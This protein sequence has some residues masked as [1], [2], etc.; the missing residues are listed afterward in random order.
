MQRAIFWVGLG[1]IAGAAAI[2][3][4]WRTK[5]VTVPPISSRKPNIL[6]ISSC[7]LRYAHLATYSR[8]TDYS[9]TITE[10][11]R[12][13]FVF[14]NAVTE[15][16]WTN[17][18]NFLAEDGVRF[19]MKYGYQM[20]GNRAHDPDNPRTR[21]TSR[22]PY[23][24]RITDSRDSRRLRGGERL[25]IKDY[26]NE[27]E[28]AYRTTPKPFL[29]QVHI[30]AMHLPYLAMSQ[31]LRRLV[32]RKYPPVQ[33]Y[34]TTPEK[35]PE[36][37]ALFATLL[38]SSQMADYLHVHPKRNR[39]STDAVLKKDRSKFIGLAQNPEFLQDW[40]TSSDFVEDVRLLKM[41]YGERLQWY[42]QEIA[43]L[44][45]LF[46]D[47]ELR[48]NTVIIFTGDHGEAM[49]EHGL[50][51]HGEAPWEE[52]IRIPLMVYFPG[53][54]TQIRL[55]G[56]I[57]SASTKELIEGLMSGELRED[58]FVEWVQKNIHDD[59]AFGRDCPN[60][61]QSVRYRNQW[62]LF[63]SLGREKWQLFDLKNDPGEVHDV[64]QRYPG[65]AA[66]LREKLESYESTPTVGHP[67]CNLR[68][69][70]SQRLRKDTEDDQDE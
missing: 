11:G 51:A 7:S 36:K 4:H 45:S 15:L 23:F 48:R 60:L 6:V 42:D 63:Y 27:L 3:W 5:P 21:R 20:I 32:A 57:R 16:T 41:I 39:L 44:I 22:I 38:P 10:L 65:I 17:L 1:A 9:P 30:K 26:M 58:N 40:I 12:R 24:F 56:Q 25:S 53:Q 67:A 31:D 18:V 46:G 70:E 43:P 49:M 35:F 14:E 37:M 62:K 33:R 69:S 52:E 47:P 64:A 8:G 68:N 54:Q 50:L 61:R 2:G 28:T 59:Y 66:H 34:L 13:S 55:P 19:A 29:S